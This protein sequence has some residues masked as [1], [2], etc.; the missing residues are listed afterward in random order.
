MGVGC[1]GIIK[2]YI[3][4]GKVGQEVRGEKAGIPQ[5]SG[6]WEAKPTA[7]CVQRGRTSTKMQKHARESWEVG[8]G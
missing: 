4:Q 2:C 6:R 3:R 7:R 8:V 1:L 5:N